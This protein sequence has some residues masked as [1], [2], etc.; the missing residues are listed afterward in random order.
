[1]PLDPALNSL[2]FAKPPSETRVVVAMSGGVDSSVV[3]AQLAEGE[4]NAFDIASAITEWLRENI[5]YVDEVGEIPEGFEP[6]DYMLF[7]DQQGFC[8]Y[9]ATAEILMLRSLGI[10]ARL[11][12]GYAQ[13]SAE[14]SNL[15]LGGATTEKNQFL[16]GI[17]LE[18]RF[19]TVRQEQAH[20]W[21]EVYFPGYG[22]VEF[23]PTVNQLPLERPL[24]E[25]SEVLPAANVSLPDIQPQDETSNEIDA[26]VLEARLIEE[27]AQERAAQMRSQLLI[28]SSLAIILIFMVL[29]ARYRRRGGLAVPVLLERGI[30]RLNLH[31]PQ[32]LRR[33]SSYAQLEPLPKAF[34]EINSALRRL[35]TPPQRGDTPLE[36]AQALTRRIPR[37]SE[38]IEALYKRYESA[39]YKEEASNEEGVEQARWTIR[40]ASWVER[41]K[42]GLR[43]WQRKPRDWRKELGNKRD[44]KD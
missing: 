10:P 29:W 36:R 41:A 9:Y 14:D 23:E 25:E 19:F 20:A 5:N 18:T 33:W 12:V 13:G 35:G 17:A 2:G 11:A 31:A 38:L 24:D 28:L 1:M 27:E 43:R 34:M 8:N 4:E 21:P 30:E 42:Q 6:I 26:S 37:L 16:E 40:L 3:A 32:T 39:L 7:E 22:W 44:K 15:L